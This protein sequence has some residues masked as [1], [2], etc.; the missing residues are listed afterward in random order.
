MVKLFLHLRRRDVQDALGVLEHGLHRVPWGELSPALQPPGVCVPGRA[1]L[2]PPVVGR[3]R[4]RGARHEFPSLG[5]GR[6][7]LRPPRS[8]ESAEARTAASRSRSH[9][10]F[11]AHSR[12]DP[13]AGSEARRVQSTLSHQRRGRETQPKSDGHTNTGCTPKAS[14]DTLAASPLISTFS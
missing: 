4:C 12:G 6:V 1:R 8:K 11:F 2:G 14:D 13:S 5:H 9:R 10:P 7:E 3:C